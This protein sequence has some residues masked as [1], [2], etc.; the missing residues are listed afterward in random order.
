MTTAYIRALKTALTGTPDASLVLLCNFEVE[1]QWSSGHIGLPGLIGHAHNPMVARMEE[2]GVL[3]AGPDDHLVLSQPLDPA[4]RDYLI[5]IGCPPPTIHVPER[6]RP[7]RNTTDNLL[8]SPLLLDRLRR[9]ANEGAYLLPMGTGRLEQ[10]VAEITGLPLAVPDAATFERVNSKIYS[11]RI[12]EELGLRPVPGRCVE[13]VAELADAL[14]HYRE[15]LPVVVK[16]AYGVSGKGLLVLDTGAKSDRLLAMVRRRT[17]K[18]GDD[19]LDLVVEEWLPRRHDLNYQVTIDRSGTPNLDFVKRA[20]TAGGVH[21]GHIIPAGLDEAHLDVI[22]QAAA[23]VGKRL[24]AD[25]FTGVVGID[26]I[27]AEDQ[28][29]YPVLEINARLNMSTYQGGVCELFQPAG[30]VAQALHFD[31]TGPR[32]FASIGHS[33]KP[34][35][36]GRLIVTCVGTVNAATPGRLYALLVAPDMAGLEALDAEARRLLDG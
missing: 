6:A 22:R 11:R 29:L 12:T 33:L 28:T 36:D 14:A 16:E 25:G 19:R 15:R 2:L 30:S 34:L 17:A 31:L 10:R 3:L 18:S 24:A 21:K 23:A 5:G 20:L 27:L 26:A 1:A 8:D 9:L 35:L 13:S 32:D 4:Y 7:G